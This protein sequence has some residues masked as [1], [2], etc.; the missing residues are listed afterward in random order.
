M[1]GCY[2]KDL[3]ETY[4]GL[5]EVVSCR[6]PRKHTHG[7]V[8]SFLGLS[9]LR[10]TVTCSLWDNTEHMQTVRVVSERDFKTKKIRSLSKEAYSRLQS[11]NTPSV[12]GG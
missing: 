11:I 8:L 10:E 2:R 6:P 9:D 3:V 4:L 5:V 7:L 1:W 12:L